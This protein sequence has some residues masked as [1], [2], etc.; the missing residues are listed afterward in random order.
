MVYPNSNLI[1]LLCNQ[2]GLPQLKSGFMYE[3]IIING[4]KEIKIYFSI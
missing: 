2:I 4:I 1:I 3:K